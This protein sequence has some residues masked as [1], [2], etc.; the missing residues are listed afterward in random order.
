MIFFK[1]V[2]CVIVRDNKRTNITG[3]LDLFVSLSSATLA[4]MFRSRSSPVRG[5][6]TK[7]PRQVYEDK[8]QVIED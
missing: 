4:E 8:S 3:S 6:S 7:P 5:I 2:S 1:K